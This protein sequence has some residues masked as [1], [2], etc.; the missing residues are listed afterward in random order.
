[1]ATFN[2]FIFWY[3]KF[4]AKECTKDYARQMVGFHKTTWYKL[5]RDYDNGKDISRY[6]NEEDCNYGKRNRYY[7]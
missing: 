4:K 6:F 7:Y 5:C 3:R 1:M 2:N